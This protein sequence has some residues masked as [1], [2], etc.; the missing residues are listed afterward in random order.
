LEQADKMRLYLG[1]HR[2]AAA[3]LEAK[4]RPCPTA[5]K[6]ADAAFYQ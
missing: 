6:Y 1:R 5:V 4:K 2:E 3:R